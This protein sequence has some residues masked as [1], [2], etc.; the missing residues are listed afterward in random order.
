MK[1]RY[2]TLLMILSLVAYYVVSITMVYAVTPDNVNNYGRVLMNGATALENKDNVN[3]IVATYEHG[4][5]SVLGSGL[6]SDGTQVFAK[7][8]ASVDCVADA[9]YTCE[10]WRDGN[11]THG[12]SIN[13][14]NVSAKDII[15]IDATFSVAPNTQSTIFVT[16]GSGSYEI[17]RPNPQTGQPEVVHEAY[18]DQIE[19]SI[20]GTHWDS[21]S[22]IIDYYSNADTVTFTFETL[23]INRYYD[24]LVING[25]EYPISDYIDFDDR[26]SWLTHNH[27]S[28]MISFDIPN[29]PKATSYSIVA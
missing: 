7:G 10:L 5:V 14:E 18:N 26:T 8:N 28:Q 21:N 29:V 4:S 2:I 22:S 16:T 19:L 9:N 27:G 13:L 23:W 12:S 20:N 24:S 3:E 6:Y 25:H 1:K 15:N 11:N 17:S